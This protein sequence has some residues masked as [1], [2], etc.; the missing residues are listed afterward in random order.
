MVTGNVK[1]IEFENLQDAMRIAKALLKNGYQVY[2]NIEDEIGDGKIIVVIEYEFVDED[3]A[4]GRYIYKSFTDEAQEEVENSQKKNGNESEDYLRGHAEGFEA[5]WSVGYQRRVDEET[6]DDY[7]RESNGIYSEGYEDGYTNGHSDG[8][9]EGYSE[10]YETGL[11][12][13]DI[14]CFRDGDE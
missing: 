2:M 14:D 4:N 12:E 9:E 8:F 3:L 11:N 1:R 10:G 13:G 7:D 6:A 5:G